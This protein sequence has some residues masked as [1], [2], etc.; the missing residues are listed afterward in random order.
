MFQFVISAGLILASLVISEQMKFLQS[1][2]LG[3]HK[4]QQIVLPLSSQAA[5]GAYTSLKAELSRDSRISGV[6]ASRYYPGILN[7][8]DSGFRREGQTVDQSVMTRRNRVDVDFLTTLGFQPVAGR[9]FSADFPADTLY[10]LVVNETAVKKFG[11]PTPQEA[12]GQT[13]LFDWNNCEYRYQII[14]VVKDFHFEN[15]HEPIGAFSFEL[16]NRPDYNYLIAR[17][18]AG[19][20]MQALLHSIENTWKKLVPGEPMEYSFLDEDF[21]KNYKTDRQMAGLVG[22]LTGIAILISCL[23]LFGLAAF[24]AER[25]TKEIGIRKVLGASV[26]GITGL[27][28]KDFLK[29]VAIAILIAS[30]L[31]WWGLDKWLQDFEYSINMKW[32]MFALAGLLAITIAFLTVAGQAIKAALSNPVKSLRSE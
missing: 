6:G 4:E 23:G 30:P 24:A 12:V 7:A 10:H 16:N 9:L 31:A 22:S 17:A 28:A 14:G 29:L 32:W 20:D 21:Q 18:N 25:R 8:S 2:D 11:F 19:G 3:F 13:V 26:A 1:T 5:V 27:L 15:L